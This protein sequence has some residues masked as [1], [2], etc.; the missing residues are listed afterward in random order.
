VHS[1]S[2][3]SSGSYLQAVAAKSPT[4]AWAVGTTSDRT[5]IEHWTGSGWHRTAS[6]SPGG[7]PVLNGVAAS[8]AANAWA[9][10]GLSNS[11]K[12]LIL[13]WNGRSWRR[14]PSPSPRGFSV[15]SAVTATS[16]TNAWAVGY[17]SGKTLIL[18][19]DGRNWKRVPSEPGRLL[20]PAERL[21]RIADQRLGRRLGGQQNPDPPLE[22]PPLE[23]SSV[24]RLSMRRRC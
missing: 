7:S 23:L 18:H 5:L 20:H 3:S 9:V 4:N 6:P 22:R 11:G 2:P 21:S 19:W 8:S 16:F 10:G 14:V 1:P 17:A 15:L 13:H 12:T 24:T